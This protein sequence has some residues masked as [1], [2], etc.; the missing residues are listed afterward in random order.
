MH[1]DEIDGFLSGHEPVESPASLKTGARLG[2][3]RVDAFIAK[4]ASGEVYRVVNVET[5]AEGAAKVLTRTDAAQRERFRREVSF[6]RESGGGP[7]PELFDAFEAGGRE[8]SVMELLEPLESPPVPGDG[9]VAS[10]VLAVAGGV[11]ALHAKG[12]VHRDLKPQNIM[13]RKGGGPVIIDFGLMKRVDAAAEDSGA[14]S[15]ATLSIVDGHAVGLGTPHY[16]APEQF[17]GGGV[18]FASDIHALGVMANDFFGGRPPACWKKI[19]MRA[20]SSLPGQ[21]YR[22]VGAFIKAVKARHRLRNAILALGAVAAA[23]AAAWTG[24]RAH[25]AAD[26]ARWSLGESFKTPLVR[27]LALPGGGTMAFAAIPPGTFRMSNQE[28]KGTHETTLTRPFWITRTCVSAREARAL[29]PSAERDRAMKEIEGKFP[30]YDVAIADLKHKDYETICQ[31]L[32]ALYAGSLPEGYEFR[33]PTEAEL[34]Y[35]LTGG[36]TEEIA[37]VDTEALAGLECA[38]VATNGVKGVAFMP[39]NEING[40][41]VLFGFAKGVHVYDTCDG[42]VCVFPGGRSAPRVPYGGPNAI[43]KVLAYK[44]GE[45]DPVRRGRLNMSRVDGTLRFAS[46][47]KNVSGLARIA[48]APKSLRVYPGKR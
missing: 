24:M 48:I 27:E 38:D 9:D 45:T 20:A 2:A 14:G 10:L 32:N 3:W 17:T 44:D 11:G 8:V 21:R 1:E 7:F 12:F 41:G 31:R 4:G 37:V 33:L 43:G 39:R 28:G 19:V 23:V 6:L 16:S 25:H 5:G 34:E 13:R 36:G 35:A 46:S 30:R 40:W 26:G 18:S 47:G 42:T 22:D 15:V 29:L